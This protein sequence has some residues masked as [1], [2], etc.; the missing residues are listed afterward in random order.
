MRVTAKN[1][2]NYTME[3]IYNFSNFDFLKLK[4]DLKNVKHSLFIR[5]LRE[6]KDDVSKFL[7][8]WAL[9]HKFCGNRLPTLSFHPK[10][11]T[12]K[13]TPNRINLTTVLV[14]R[15][16][17]KKL[18]LKVSQNYAPPKYTSVIEFL[19]NEVAGSRPV[20]LLMETPSQVSLLLNFAKILKTIFYKLPVTH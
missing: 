6:R 8:D 14:G 15:C 19:F 9:I 20:T 7:G 16:I 3:I 1:P 5:V 18:F 11:R 4:L 12:K 13:T 17:A 2:N 10:T